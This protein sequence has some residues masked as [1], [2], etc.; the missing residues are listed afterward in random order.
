M[1]ELSLDQAPR[2][3][4]GGLIGALLV[5]GWVG[6]R[7]WGPSLSLQGWVARLPLRK[8]AYFSWE[9]MPP[10]ASAVQAGAEHREDHVSDHEWSLHQESEAPA[11]EGSQGCVVH[12]GQGRLRPGGHRRGHHSAPGIQP[13][14]GERR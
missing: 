5:G 10:G 2:P 7:G 12:A 13:E 3:G 1:R 8:L 11:E 9:H 4:P 6:G 14:G